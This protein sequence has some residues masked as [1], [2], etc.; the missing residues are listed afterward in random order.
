LRALSLENGS[1]NKPDHP[2][3]ASRR[4]LINLLVLS[5]AVLIFTAVLELTVRIVFW[6]SLDFA[7]EMWKYA[8]ELKRPV[9]DP[10]LSFVHVPNR[11]AFLM[12]VQVS[13]NSRGLR[14]RE[15]P[16]LK[17]PDT[18]RIV[19]LGDSTTLGW[20]VEQDQTIPKILERELNR[21]PIA[22][23]R[24]CEVLNSGV[25]NYDTVQ[26][27]AHY[28][29][30]DRAL[31]PD[32]VILD[33]FI[34]DAEPVPSERHPA[35]LGQ[36]Y[37][38]AFAISRY[39][40][41]LQ[42]AGVRPGWKDYYANLYAD[43]RPGLLAAQQAL[44]NLTD[45]TREEGTT[46]LVTIIPELHQIN[47]AYPFTR[48][49]QKIKDLLA[50]RHVPVIDLIDG[51]RGHGP[52]ATLWATTTDPHPNA[53]ANA[54]IVSQIAPWVRENATKHASDSGHTLPGA[55]RVR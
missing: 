35:L 26:E 53:K 40:T 4:I 15:Y 25:G 27:V 19:M 44:G 16:E 10:S 2:E 55:G 52:E 7:M 29:T 34:N 24:R 31:H 20:G 13:I 41:L 6:R 42:F 1:G 22:G 8:I 32:L 21:S 38:L 45:L 49:Q 36:S 3:V 23:Y 37:L 43:G 39:D 9:A 54:L 12:G 5:V 33:Y 46:L 51:L 14:D 47:S 30:Y 50:A 17:P 28:R 11:S 48:E 18:Y